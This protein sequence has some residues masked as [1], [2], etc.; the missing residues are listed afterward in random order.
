MLS[1]LHESS[2]GWV[3]NIIHHPSPNFRMGMQ[4][5][6]GVLGA[7]FHTMVGNLPGT[8]AEF[9][10]AAAQLSAHFG[11]GQ[12]GTCIQWVNVRGAEAWAEAGGNPFWYS[13]EMAD[14]GN[15]N[16]P[17]TEAQLDRAAQLAE[18][19]SRPSVGNFPLQVTDSVTGEGLGTHS[20]GGAAWGGHSCP[21]APP[22][23]VRSSQR[24]EIVR[25]AKLLRAGPQDVRHVAEGLASLDW[26]ANRLGTTSTHLKY[27]TRHSHEI[28]AAELAS[29]NLYAKADT[30]TVMPKGL[31]WYSDAAA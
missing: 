5:P 28:T 8:D 26:Q 17:Y 11:I 24:Q 7:L 13:C 15:P 25:R 1:K 9:D 21:D 16:N 12:D 10:N 14:N 18:F 2:P 20:M 31:V 3:A 19:L 27:V 23:H 6:H 4:V 30:S 22:N 29:F